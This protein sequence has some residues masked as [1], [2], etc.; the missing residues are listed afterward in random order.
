[1]ANVEI[2]DMTREAG[3]I[4]IHI[5]SPNKKS[6]FDKITCSIFVNGKLVLG[7]QSISQGEFNTVL[8]MENSKTRNANTFTASC[9]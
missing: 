9:K 3:Y 7:G 5:H 6:Y 2:L 1:M 4:K 8:I